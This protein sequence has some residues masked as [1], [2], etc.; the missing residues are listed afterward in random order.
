MLA[1]YQKRLQALPTIINSLHEIVKADEVCQSL[2]DP[3]L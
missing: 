3:S 1:L 2:Q